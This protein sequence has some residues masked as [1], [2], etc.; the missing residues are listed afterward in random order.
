MITLYHAPQS[1]SSRMIWLLEELALPYSIEYVTISR[2]DGSDGPDVR[3]PHPDKKVPAIV[4]EDAVIT[5]S[6]AICLYLTDLASNSPLAVPVG[7][8]KRGALLTWLA[9][10]CGVIEPVVTI[11]VAG[12]GDN[13]S[14]TR[15]F[16]G[17][18][19]VDS[20]LTSAL[21]GGSWLLGDQ[22]T[23][24][25]VL[26]A[27]MGHWSRKMLPAE[28]WMDEYLNRANARPALRRALTKDRPG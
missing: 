18:A 24:A 23:A 6:A 10:Y 7:S 17:R 26:I 15:T 4:H 12:L 22:F 13:P 27:S 21:K 8:P 9:Y 3:N 25:D 2:M 1:R 14:L 5:E 28:A 16:R 11:A 20:R 19:E